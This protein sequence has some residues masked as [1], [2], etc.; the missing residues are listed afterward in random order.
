MKLKKKRETLEKNKER[1]SNIMVNYPPSSQNIYALPNILPSMFP[2]LENTYPSTLSPIKK[3]VSPTIVS[4]Q[5]DIKK[6]LSIDQLL[7]NV[8]TPQQIPKSQF[9]SQ[10]CHS[11]PSPHNTLHHLVE[12]S[13]GDIDDDATMT[14]S[15]PSHQLEHKNASHGIA[16]GVED[17]PPIALIANILQGFR[18]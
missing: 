13:S 2:G 11:G 6:P 10:T 7:N 3:D 16:K 1:L 8:E 5:R 9:T 18:N 12:T 17:D 4:T 15:T 14:G